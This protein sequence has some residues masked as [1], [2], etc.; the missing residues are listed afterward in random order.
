MYNCKGCGR[1]TNARGGFCYRCIAHEGF[2]T[3]KGQIHDTKDRQRT[4]KNME[5]DYGAIEDMLK[6]YEE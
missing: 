4:E 1:D 3:T 6:D 5:L 2:A